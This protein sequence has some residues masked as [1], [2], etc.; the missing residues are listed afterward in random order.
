MLDS[1]S[2]KIET[3]KNINDFCEANTI[4]TETTKNE[5]GKR[6]GKWKNFLVTQYDDSPLLYFNG[7]LS[8]FYNQT[9]GYNEFGNSY[10]LNFE[11]CSDAID[12]LSQQ[13][14]FPANELVVTAFE[15]GFETI[16]PKPIKYY[17]KLITGL[18]PADGRP[19]YSVDKTHKTTIYFHRGNGLKKDCLAIYDKNQERKDKGMKVLDDDNLTKIEMRLQQHLKQRLKEKDDI[20]LARFQDSTFYDKV[21]K[22]FVDMIY[23]IYSY[24]RI[25]DSIENTNCSY[26]KAS[27]CQKWGVGLLLNIVQCQIDFILDKF[28]GVDSITKHRVKTYFKDCIR[29][30]ETES[31]KLSEIDTLTD[32]IIDRIPD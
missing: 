10:S 18:K 7:S 23:G 28:T 13:I 9:C 24:K 25:D 29:K 8:K 2:F 31:N 16:F 12:I 27:E 32:L 4:K 15:F 17:M 6:T 20:T 26:T 22:R 30:F 5:K 14:G 21:K 11:E 1:I 3:H 19:E